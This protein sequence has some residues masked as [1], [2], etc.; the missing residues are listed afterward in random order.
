MYK[1]CAKRLIVYPLYKQKLERIHKNEKNC[2]MK[3]NVAITK[4]L[5]R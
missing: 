2:K 3:Y 4:K 1:A 5:L